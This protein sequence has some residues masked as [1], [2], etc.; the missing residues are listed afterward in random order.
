MVILLPVFC[1]EVPLYSHPE[2]RRDTAR[3]SLA[4][5]CI[6]TVCVSA[7]HTEALCSLHASTLASHPRF[8][9][10]MTLESIFTNL[11]P[12]DLVLPFR[13]SIMPLRNSSANISENSVAP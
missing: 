5:E 3:E 8:N 10:S 1:L 11:A 12:R 7:R 13:I 2:S 6:G 4:H 9:Y